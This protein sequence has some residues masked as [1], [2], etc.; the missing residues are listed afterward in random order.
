MCRRFTPGGASM[1][2]NEWKSLISEYSRNKMHGDRVTFDPPRHPKINFRVELYTEIVKRCQGGE[3]S[4]VG[5]GSDSEART[6]PQGDSR[7]RVP[8]VGDTKRRELNGGEVRRWSKIKTHFFPPPFSPLR[9]PPFDNTMDF[10]ATAKRSS[11]RLLAV[12]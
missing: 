6:P 9:L 12:R 11:L 8:K 2:A 5:V 3:L 4:A 7:S 1:C 10:R